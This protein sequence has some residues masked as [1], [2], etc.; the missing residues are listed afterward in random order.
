MHCLGFSVSKFLSNRNASYYD[1]PHL[2]RLKYLAVQRKLN[3]DYLFF[4]FF[5]WEMAKNKMYQILD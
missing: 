1:I 2:G 3:I 4:F 5:L